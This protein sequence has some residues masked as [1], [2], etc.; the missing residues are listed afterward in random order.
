MC[1]YSVLGLAGL[2]LFAIAGC[3]RDSLSVSETSSELLVVVAEGGATFGDV[4]LGATSAPITVRVSQSGGADAF[5]T[6][7]A[8]TESCPNFSADPGA[9]PRD[10]YKYCIDGGGGPIPIR[11]DGDGEVASLACPSGYEFANYTFP[12]VF[13]PT[14]AGMQSCVISVSTSSGVKTV[15]LTGNGLAPL[16]EIELSRSSVAFGD[17]RVGQTSSPQAITVSNLG[18]GPLTITSAAV[19]GGGFTLTGATTAVDPNGAY[20]FQVAC[21]PPSAQVLT[22]TFTVTSNDADEASVSL[23]LSCRGI[24]SALDVRPSPIAM[25]AARLDEPRE[26]DISLLNAGAAPMNVTAV[27][28]TGTDLE[29]VPANPATIPATI[30]ANTA[31]AVRVRY[32]AREEANISGTLTVAFDGQVRTVEISA[33]ARKASLSL[34][35]DGEVDLG[36]ICVGATKLQ[37]F[38]A[39]GAGGAGFAI[40]QVTLTGDG[41]TLTSAPG[42]IVISGAGITAALRVSVQPTAAGRIA[43]TLNLVTDIPN[44]TMRSVTMTGSAF[45]AGVGA[46]PAAHNFGSILVDEPSQ[47]QQ[48]ALAN[49]G[50]EP[51]S[52]VSSELVGLDATDFRVVTELP[53][54]VAPGQSGTM[55]VEMR[56]RTTG[57][58]AATLTITHSAGVTEVPLS[59]D[60]FVP[61]VAPKRIGTYYACSTGTGAASWWLTLGVVAWWARRRRRS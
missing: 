52:I 33:S 18:S 12:V 6:V 24:A 60:G 5:D 17:V 4:S 21:T 41:F 15:T 16:R 57:D 27:S 51:L 50:S 7:T 10:V 46:A 1:R 38:Q 48:I 55:L 54:V 56:P 47:V 34:T 28:V 26:L 30:P 58:K 13:S 31:L 11:G 61:Y 8:V 45:A 35:P 49:C 39:L 53:K 20:T 9:L 36:A 44:E 3:A 42:P 25:P 19:T 43:G 37:D 22:G 14:V 2:L 59:G 29:L 23:P 32:L 40:S